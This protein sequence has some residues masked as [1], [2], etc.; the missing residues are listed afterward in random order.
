MKTAIFIKLLENNTKIQQIETAELK[1]IVKDLSEN[2]DV[3]VLVS[4]HDIQD[5]TEVCERIVLLEKGRVIKDL[6]TSPETLKELESYFK[7]E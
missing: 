4:S 5:V 6:V 7:G 2:K 3:T 1:A